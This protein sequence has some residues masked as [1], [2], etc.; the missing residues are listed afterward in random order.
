[1]YMRTFILL[2]FSVL[3]VG[4]VT[5]NEPDEAVV[6]TAE[7]MEFLEPGLRPEVLLFPE[8]FLM[9]DFEL[10]QHGIVPASSLV[11]GGLKTEM[12]LK[13]VRRRFSD[14]LAAN[15][16]VVDNFEIEKRSF[17]IKASLAGEFIEIR[18]VQGDG[19]TQVFILYQPISSVE[20]LK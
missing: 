12:E 15:D 13:I 9:E 6:N 1:M 17:R 16:W 10:N 5:T 3:L 18:A 4:C 19:P 20:P 14:V 8:Y 2:L 11:G 7:S